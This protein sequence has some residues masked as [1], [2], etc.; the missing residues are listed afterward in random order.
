MSSGCNET[1]LSA[2]TSDTLCEIYSENSVSISYTTVGY[3]AHILYHM[4][5]SVS[6]KHNFSDSYLHY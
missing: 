4:F 5:T 3:I 1:K 6:D 2:N